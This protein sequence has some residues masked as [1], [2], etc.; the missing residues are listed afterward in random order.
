MCA[1]VYCTLTSHSS[2]LLTAGTNSLSL[3]KL[4]FISHHSPP[5][6]VTV[7][8]LTATTWQAIL[9]PPLR[10]H[11]Y[12]R[13]SCRS[14][15]PQVR[16][17]LACAT[18]SRSS[19]YHSHYSQP[20]SSPPSHLTAGTACAPHPPRRTPT[21]SVIAHHRTATVTAGTYC[22]PLQQQHRTIAAVLYRPATVQR[23]H[24][25]TAG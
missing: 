2:H 12:H 21:Q 19:S 10:L 11:S 23:R 6:P 13:H 14:H 24:V 16:T 7:T 15:P 25:R 1:A 20:H 3:S 8:P 18:S 17:A 5:A 4:T 22:A 9:H